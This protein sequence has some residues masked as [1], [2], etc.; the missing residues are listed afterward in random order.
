M[1]RSSG[2]HPRDTYPRTV[3]VDPLEV[4]PANYEKVARELIA[5]EGLHTWGHPA[6]VRNE[7]QDGKEMVAVTF[8]VSRIEPHSCTRGDC[9]V[10]AAAGSLEAT[11]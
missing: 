7:R 11:R 8:T 6:S 3:L 1:P 4:E 9:A 2:R 5:A 10:C